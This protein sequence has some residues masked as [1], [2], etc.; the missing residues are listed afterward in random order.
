VLV[1]FAATIP[2]RHVHAGEV[3][4]EDF[5]DDL[6]AGPADGR[7]R[8]PSSAVT[9]APIW[10]RPAMRPGSSF[11]IEPKCLCPSSPQGSLRAIT[12]CLRDIERELHTIRTRIHHQNSRVFRILTPITQPRLMVVFRKQS[13]GDLKSRSISL[14]AEKPVHTVRQV[15]GPAP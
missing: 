5:L 10:M 4:C 8:R 7:P 9:L 6:K 11:G 14:Q 1:R 2:L 15:F 13:L 12:S 3:R